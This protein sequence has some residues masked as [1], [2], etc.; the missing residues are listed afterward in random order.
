M[1]PSPRYNIL[2]DSIIVRWGKHHG[3]H[4]IR[5]V[6]PILTTVVNIP[7]G[8][9]DSILLYNGCTMSAGSLQIDII[10]GRIISYLV[11]LSRRSELELSSISRHRDLTV[12]WDLTGVRDQ[13]SE[14]PVL[15]SAGSCPRQSF[16]DFASSHA[17]LRQPDQAR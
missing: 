17:R 11:I 5:W 15:G 8:K 13:T 9:T 16:T 10:H 2:V 4:R 1:S 7:N 14:P 6:K 3:H 12:E